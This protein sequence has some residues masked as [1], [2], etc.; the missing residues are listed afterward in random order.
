MPIMIQLTNHNGE[1]IWLN[2]T[3][4]SSIN[5]K[6]HS[7]GIFMADGRYLEVDETPEEIREKIHEEYRILK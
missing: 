5:P 6:A 7:T 1:P 3:R 2:A 4:M